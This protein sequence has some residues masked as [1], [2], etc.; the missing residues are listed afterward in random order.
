[1]VE[2]DYATTA[3]TMNASLPEMRAWAEH[4]MT[5]HEPMRLR[6]LVTGEVYLE[7]WFIVPRNDVMNF[8]LHRFLG[9]DDDRAMHDHR[10]DN[11]SWVIDGTYLEYFRRGEYAEDGTLLGH[12]REHARVVEAGTRVTRR[13]EDFHR[14]ELLDGRPVISLSQIGPTSRPSWG[15]DCPSGW[16]DWREFD[17]QNGCG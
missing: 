16:V 7:R 1:M 15:F 4:Y 10:G 6:S 9:S 3:T 8:Y 12:E 2:L 5:A 11:T 17:R 14:I 13:A